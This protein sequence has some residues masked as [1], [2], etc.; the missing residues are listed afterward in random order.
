MFL[1]IL[2]KDATTLLSEVQSSAMV[3]SCTLKIDTGVT[4]H[5]TSLRRLCLTMALTE[6]KIAY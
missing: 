4:I 2:L 1:E 5:D 6:L 3:R